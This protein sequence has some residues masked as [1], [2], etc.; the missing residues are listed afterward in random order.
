MQ[1]QVAP[2]SDELATSRSHQTPAFVDHTSKPPH[3]QKM[4]GKKKATG[5]GDLVPPPEVLGLV[6]SFFTQYGLESTKNAFAKELKRLQQ[7]A[8]WP[9]PPAAETAVDLQ[10][11]FMKWVE[12]QK[13]QPAES[14]SESEDAT[15]VSENTSTSSTSSEDSSDSSEVS[16]EDDSSSDESSTSED[17]IKSK[18]AQKPQR[19]KVP[20]RA[21]SPSSS[22][23]SSASDSDADDEDENKT[24]TPVKST[25]GRKKSKTAPE[26]TEA[27]VKKN[28]KR[29]AESSSSESSS[30]DSE[31]DS[32]DD[33]RAAKRTKVNTKD[34]ADDASTSET[35]TSTSE[36]SDEDENI[37]NAGELANG[38][39]PVSVQEASSE[40]SGTVRGDN[41]DVD[42]QQPTFEDDSERTPRSTAPLKKK[43]TGA[44]PTPLA[45]LSAHATADSHI[46][47]A[48]QSYEYAERAYNDLSV[49][50]GKGFTKEKNKKKRGS[51]RGGP[52]DI[53][54][55]KGF[56]FD[57]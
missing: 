42:T 12:E 11:T 19:S 49:T 29:K 18:S 27:V 1:L 20:K 16:S 57:D 51:Y 37:G 21:A 10:S 38:T 33:E 31:S 32:S 9:A 52:I 15:S 30:S 3:R 39:K 56:K 36:E 2:T 13:T 6:G 24:A 25:A 5:N 41:M 48:Y 22:S 46:S 34:G 45:Q 7:T 40:S 4:K 44:K 26:T 47:N 50:R 55:G 35:S 54:G 28:L 23:S 17:Q 43:H 53:S 8:D 14:T